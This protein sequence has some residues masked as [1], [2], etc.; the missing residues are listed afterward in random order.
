M[1]ELEQQ[2][3]EAGWMERIVIQARLL[4]LEFEISDW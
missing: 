2:L 1:Y 3:K 4:L